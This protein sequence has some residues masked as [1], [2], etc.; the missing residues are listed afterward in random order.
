MTDSSEPHS[1]TPPP[2]S[3]AHRRRKS[4]A[5]HA[6]LFGGKGRGKLKFNRTKF[7]V[8]GG[9]A[10]V[11]I[12]AVVAIVIHADLD[13][14]GVNEWIGELNPWL[15]LPLMAVLPIAGFPIAVVYLFAGARFGPYWGGVVVAAVTAIHLLATYAISRSFLRAPL[16]RMMERRHWHLP[17]VPED[18]QAAVCVVAAL[19]PGLPYFVRNYLLAVAGV[20]LKYLL[21]VVMP[22][23]VAR[24]YVTILL[25]DMGADPSKEKLFI[26][27][28]VDALK[29][30]ICGYVIW[31]LR[32][33]H[34]KHHGHE[35]ESG[36][37][38]PHDHDSG[39][40]L[41]PSAAAK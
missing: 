7:W 18:E 41:P 26:L 1:P 37:E 36:G 6:L 32:Q 22:I 13:W 10:L 8:G 27:L 40:L 24:S 9:V 2:T 35:H 16:K 25:G 29:I 39:A 14:A 31:R 38:E 21:L 11:V 3:P 4:G 28:G 20:R 30:I 5:H 12:A 17:E 19:A 15:V 23:Y 34:R 33:H